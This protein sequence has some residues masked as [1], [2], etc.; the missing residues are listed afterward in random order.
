MFVTQ[1]TSNVAQSQSLDWF[2]QTFYHLLKVSLLL[3]TSTPYF[4]NV[5]PDSPL[6][7]RANFRVNSLVLIYQNLGLHFCAGL[8]SKLRFIVQINT[9][10]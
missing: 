1:F 8:I 10:Q 3:V 4:E 6:I 9:L 7:Q 2:E 5:A